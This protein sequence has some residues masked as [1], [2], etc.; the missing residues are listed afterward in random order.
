MNKDVLVSVV[1]I[2]HDDASIIESYI[3]DVVEILAESFKN[4]ELLLVANGSTDES[5]AKIKSIQSRVKNIRLIS[6]SRQYDDEVAY[7]AAL[8]NCLGDFVILMN[9]NYDPPSL[10]PQLVEVALSGYDVVIAERSDRNDDTWLDKISA[11][12]F[13]KI[14][15]F[16]TGYNINPNSSEYFIFSRRMVN[17]IIQIKDRIRYIKYLKLEVGYKQTYITYERIMRLG[18]KK[19]KS[20]LKSLG[21]AVDVIVSNSDKMLKLASLI[22]LLTS[23]VNL[24]YGIYVLAISIFKK[25][26]IE[27][28]ASTSLF[29]STMFFLLFLILSIIGV[30]I[31]RVLKETKKGPL[32][33]ISDESNSS[34]L[35]NDLN[36]KNVV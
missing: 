20:F 22:G 25:N 27:G 30:Y 29:N 13:Y 6:L 7:M 10:I 28:W 4:Y 14:S 12:L 34:V 32:Y 23:F 35:F 18:Y 24:L 36:C 1:A 33:Y 16:F 5:I 17:S 8:E 21:F 15:K 2:L 3:K 11:K 9:I 26:V 31:S 19:K